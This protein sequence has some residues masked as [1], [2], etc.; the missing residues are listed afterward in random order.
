M[1]PEEN[2]R[3]RLVMLIACAVVSAAGCGT[4][5]NLADSPGGGSKTAVVPESCYPFGGVHR[6]AMLGVFG[7]GSGPMSVYNGVFGAG[8]SQ[9]A[10]F[11]AGLFVVG[12]G[13]L[14]DTPVSLVGDIVTLPVAYAREQEAPWASWWGWPD[15]DAR[16][17]S[18]PASPGRP[19]PSVPSDP[20]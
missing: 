20:H 13:A 14:I 5:M 15:F 9:S 3:Q 7:V 4:V 11:Q 16:P 12:V 17:D 6:S 2:M 8:D 18:G 10:L 1:P 19:L